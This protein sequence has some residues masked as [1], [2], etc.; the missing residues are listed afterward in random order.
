MV[1]SKDPHTLSPRLTKNS[2][3]KLSSSLKKY[4]DCFAWD[5]HEMSGLSPDVVEHKLPNKHDKKPVKKT[6][7]RFAP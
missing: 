5:Y 4:K 1:Q 7:R 2:R 6:P 3:L